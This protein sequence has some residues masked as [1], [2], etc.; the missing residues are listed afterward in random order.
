MV[1]LGNRATN[2]NYMI[3]GLD[4]SEDGS[5]IV[6]F[7][8]AELGGPIEAMIWDEQNGVR[9]LETVL[10]LMGVDTDGWSL[11]RVTA[12][13]YDGRHLTGWGT[14]P[15]G[16]RQGF[17][18]VIP[19]PNTAILMVLGLCALSSRHS[20]TG[21]SRRAITNVD[22]SAKATARLNAP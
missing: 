8:I 20:R 5:V 6:G 4:T 22:K 17:L 7:G 1:A 13:S 21:S 19:E 15:D 18:A 10:Q 12:V 14:N 16:D 9:D 2:A 11:D 3:S